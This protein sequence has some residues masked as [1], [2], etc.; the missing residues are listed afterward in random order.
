MNAI[1]AT[2]E[3]GKFPPG[4][5]AGKVPANATYPAKEDMHLIARLLIPAQPA[6]TT[7][8]CLEHPNFWMYPC[9]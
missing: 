5:A 4:A 8:L 2:I 1:I 6:E 9:R 7:R 3:I